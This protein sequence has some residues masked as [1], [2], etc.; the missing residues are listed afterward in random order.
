MPL[1]SKLS[2]AEPS[3]L[4]KATKMVAL[5]E[6]R[7]Y[8]NLLILLTTSFGVLFLDNEPPTNG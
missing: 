4:E 7:R 1:Q 5:P 3:V 2:K 6:R 8:N